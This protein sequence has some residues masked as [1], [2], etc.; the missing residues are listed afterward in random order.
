MIDLVNMLKNICQRNHDALEYNT[1]YWVLSE[2]YS[3]LKKQDSSTGWMPFEGEMPYVT[4]LPTETPKMK[5]RDGTTRGGVKFADLCLWNDANKSWAWLELKAGVFRGQ[6][7]FQK[8]YFDGFRNDLKALRGFTIKDTVDAW[9]HR[10]K[11]I[12]NYIEKFKFDYFKL[13]QR[14]RQLQT[15]I[16]HFNVAYIQVGVELDSK[17]WHREGMLEQ[18]RSWKSNMQ[19][20]Y[21]REVLESLPDIDLSKL[22]ID[23]NTWLVLAQ[24]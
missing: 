10:D 12:E 3:D 6:A 9:E 24:W 1:E 11:S 14:S 18:V 23:K 15:G 19:S 21:G 22:Q 13:E 16:Q 8:Y 17:L 5:M 4:L 7:R 20:Q 2:L